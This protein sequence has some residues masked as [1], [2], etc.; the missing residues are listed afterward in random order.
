VG[1]KAEIGIDINFAADILRRGGLVAMPTETVYGLAANA[2]NPRAVISIFEAKN[3]PAFDPLIV[4]IGDLEQV[5]EVASEYPVAAQKLTEQYWPGPLTIVLKKRDTIPDIVTSGLQTVGVRMPRHPLTLRLLRK[6]GFPVAAPSANPFGYVSPTTAEHVADQLGDR[7]EYILDGGPCDVGVESTIV[8]FAEEKPRILRAGGLIIEDIRNIVGDVDVV[9]GSDFMPSAPGMLSEH[10][11]PTI[12]VYL[13]DIPAM[14]KTVPGDNH[15][16]LGFK[17]TYGLKGE[18]LSPE[19]DMH[20]AAKNLF[21]AIRRLDAGGYDAILAEKVPDEG[22]G[23]AI[24]DRLTRAS[25]P[26]P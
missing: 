8:S 11:K 6:I 2:L 21:A 9:D 22:L 15:A 3:R 24:N 10:Y 5:A 25:S 12:P 13:G 4:H 18:V 17:S 20:E 1:V 26:M 14:A 16:A 23:K 19:G 7:I